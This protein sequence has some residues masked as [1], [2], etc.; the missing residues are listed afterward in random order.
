MLSFLA[1]GLSLLCCQY[2]FRGRLGQAKM[3]TDPRGLLWMLASQ[4][5]GECHRNLHAPKPNLFHNWECCWF[6]TLGMIGITDA[7]DTICVSKGRSNTSSRWRSEGRRDKESGITGQGGRYQE[8]LGQKIG[9]K[10]WGR[11]IDSVHT[12]QFQV[13]S[14]EQRW[15]TGSWQMS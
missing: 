11:P 4:E 1:R 7:R 13:M 14:V 9:S 10:C 5:G 8:C 3:C 2:Q 12:T 15:L 6:T